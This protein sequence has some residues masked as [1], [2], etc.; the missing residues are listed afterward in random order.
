MIVHV[1]VCPH[2]CLV[3]SRLLMTINAVLAPPSLV[4]SLYAG[5]GP[6]DPVLFEG[7][8]GLQPESGPLPAP[9]Y[10]PGRSGKHPQSM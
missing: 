9:D 10:R 2:A 8:E 7:F 6:I 4:L 5:T 1:A 3:L